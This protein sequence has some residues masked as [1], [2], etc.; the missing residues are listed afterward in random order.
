MRFS[1]L[2]RGAAVALAAVGMMIPN[3]PAMA[4]GPSR[5]QVKMVDAKIFDIAVH[6]TIWGGSNFEFD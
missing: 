6:R 2:L 5:A 3:A 1:S 4:A